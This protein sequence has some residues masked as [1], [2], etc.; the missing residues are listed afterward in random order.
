MKTGDKLIANRN[1]NINEY[2][3]SVRG[4][5]FGT[6]TISENTAKTIAEHIIEGNIITGNI[7]IYAADYNS[8]D[9]IKMNDVMQ[10]INGE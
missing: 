1:N 3:L 5:I 6:G 8:D 2:I 7:S 10:I 9:V 4:D